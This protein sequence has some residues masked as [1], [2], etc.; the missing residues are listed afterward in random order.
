[1]RR[2]QVAVAAIAALTFVLPLQARR[3]ASG[4]PPKGTPDMPMLSWAGKSKVVNHHNDVPFRV[5]ERKWIFN[6]E[7]QSRREMDELLSLRGVSES[8]S[9]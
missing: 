3:N 8:R 2:Y 9:H 1:M 5:L 4:T 6:A 7:T